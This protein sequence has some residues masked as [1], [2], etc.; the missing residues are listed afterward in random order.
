MAQLVQ[1][2]E[3]A[4][5][6]TITPR[7]ST[8]L[9][10][11]ARLAA[12]VA[13]GSVHVEHVES[14]DVDLLRIASRDRAGLFAHIAG[15]LALHGLDIIGAAATTGADGVAV[16]EFRIARVPSGV[17][18]NWAKVEHDLRA[19]LCG[20]TDVDAR[21]EARLKS[22]SRRR[23]AMAAIAPRLEVLISN[24]AS[25]SSTVVEVRAPDAPAVLYRLSHALAGLGLDIGSAVV[26]TLGHEVVDVFY[27][28]AAGAKLPVDVH[29]SVRSALK[30]ALEA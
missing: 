3:E 8:E 20:E 19:A 27:V 18:P 4:L 2:T 14:A 29:D 30:A 28:T 11:S 7:R 24:D 9:P 1:L 5:A 12:L 16:D 23:K 26:A 6:G 13:D 25:E 15:A 21:L 10:D 17:A 22:Q